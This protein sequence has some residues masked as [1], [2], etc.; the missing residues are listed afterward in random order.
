M[1]LKLSAKVQTDIQDP[2]NDINLKSLTIYGSHYYQK[3]D[4]EKLTAQYIFDMQTLI[5]RIGEGTAS[6]D[7]VHFNK[8]LDTN[9]KFGTA[10]ITWNKADAEKYAM[11]DK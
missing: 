3:G 5:D 8:Y 1:N 4:M 2:A 11:D 6:E 10:T 7:S 9:F